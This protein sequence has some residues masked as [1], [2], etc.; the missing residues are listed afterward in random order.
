MPVPEDKDGQ[1]QGEGRS[2]TDDFLDKL[3][4]ERIKLVRT[5][6]SKPD[7]PMF[8]VNHNGSPTGKNRKGK[9]RKNIIKIRK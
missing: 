7:R 5:I 3:R 2:A 8:S 1:V 9:I 4:G 6:S